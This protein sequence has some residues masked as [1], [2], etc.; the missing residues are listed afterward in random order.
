MNLP[1]LATFLYEGLWTLEIDTTFVDT[2]V[3]LK[4]ETGCLLKE[5]PSYFLLTV[6]Q[7]IRDIFSVRFNEEELSACVKTLHARYKTF[8]EVL[9]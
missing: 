2:L 7:E 1:P 8:K 6:G 9:A 3:R 4:H 5:F